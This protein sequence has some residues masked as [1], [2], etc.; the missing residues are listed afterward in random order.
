MQ[1]T[2]TVP[3]ITSILVAAARA[4]GARDRD[5]QVRNPD[6]LAERLVGPNERALLGPVNTLLDQSFDIEVPIARLLIPRTHFIDARLKTAVGEGIAQLVI[7]GAGFDT[8]PYRFSEMLK[9][10]RVF[11]V[12]HP[13]TQQVKIRRVWEAIGEPPT[14]LAYVAVDL[15]TAELGEALTRAGYQA[16]RKTFFIWEG[17]T[18]YLPAE[19]VQATLTWIASNAARESAVVFDYTYETPIKLMRDF[20]VDKLPE[21][22]KQAAMRFR[23]V[24]SGEPWI[25]GLPDKA[26]KE[27]LNSLGLELRT[28]LGM[29]SREAVERYL[30]RADG[31]IFGTYPATE[32]Q[33]YLILEAAVP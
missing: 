5:P 10:V 22:A 23:N 25:F 13:D 21:S 32:Q 30:T 4:L 12:D 15:R 9:D 1:G 33:G 6:W 29:N 7:L 17:V 18:M 19:A 8:R 26:E 28:L 14:N 24:M 20:D 27:F 16:D 31:T 2:F 11:E 3:S